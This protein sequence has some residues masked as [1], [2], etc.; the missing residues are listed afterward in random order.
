MNVQSREAI[1][2]LARQA[3]KQG[4][5]VCHYPYGSEERAIWVDAYAAALDVIEA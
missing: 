5:D 1:K 2:Q 4:N 3:A